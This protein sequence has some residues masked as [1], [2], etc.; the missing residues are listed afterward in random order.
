[1]GVFVLLSKHMRE[2]EIERK[3]EER[4]KDFV[5]RD[6]DWTFAIRSKQL[7]KALVITT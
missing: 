1:M 7:H 5:F 2:K 3:N 4:K 6:I